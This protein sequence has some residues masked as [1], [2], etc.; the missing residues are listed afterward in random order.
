MALL[1]SIM[2]LFGSRQQ[3]AGPA[4]PADPATQQQQ[5]LA[6]GANPNVPSPT[7][8]LSNGSLP[9]IPAAGQ[10]TESPLANFDEL[11]KTDPS[12]TVETPSL[13]PSFNLDHK[14][15][16]EAAKKVNF[17]NHI[18]PELVTKAL[19]GDAVA[20]MDVLNQVA[21]LNFA[22]STAATGEIVK[23]SLGSAQTVLKDSVLPAAFRDQQISQALNESNPIFSDPSV[24]PMLGM[25]KSQLAIKYPTATPQ[26]IAATAAEYLGSVS[27]KI[28]TA[29]GGTITPKS[30]QGRNQTFGSPQE[31]DWSK[32]FN[33]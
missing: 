6:A 26:Q 18:A 33:E 9:A 15:L 20:F 2:S 5:T 17:T 23:Q 24:S 13:V 21:Q 29:S 11:W 4:N 31:T 22:N 19:S 12:K 14:G 8:P 25:L 27:N 16:M 10:G 30:S 3:A 28:V 7:T 32:F 1:P